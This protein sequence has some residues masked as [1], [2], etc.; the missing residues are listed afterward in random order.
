LNKSSS[1]VSNKDPLDKFGKAFSFNK[2][3]LK[4]KNNKLLKDSL[5]KISGIANLTD[6]VSRRK[7]SMTLT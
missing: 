3:T 2:K 4:A 7:S 6:R 1:K 5:Y